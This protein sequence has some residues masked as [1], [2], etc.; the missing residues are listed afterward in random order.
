MRQVLILIATGLLFVIHSG[1]TRTS[2]NKQS[3]T[4]EEMELQ[5]KVDAFV[6]VPLTCNI[7]HLSASDR[8]VLSL[9]FDAAQLMDDLFW[10]EAYGDKES[11][12]AQLPN[13]TYRDFARINYGPWERLNG[14]E[15]FVATFGAKPLGANFYPQDITKEEFE[16]CTDPLKESMY[17]VL[18]RDKEGKLKVIPYHEFFAEKINQAAKLLDSA[19]NLAEDSGLKNYLTLRANA[20]RTDEYFASDMAWM[21]MKN[22]KIDLVVGPIENYEDHLYGTKAAHEAFVLVKDLEW[23]ERLSRYMSFLPELQKRLPIEDKYKSELPGTESDLGVYDVVFYAGDCNAGSKTIAINLPNDVKVQEQKGSRRLQLRN[24]MQYK[25]NMIMEPIANLLIDPAQRNYVTFEAFF[26]NT[27]FHE[28]AH[29]LGIK[30]TL[31]GKSTPQE[32]LL[33]TYSSIEE[34][35]ADILGIFMLEQLTKLGEL[36]DHDMMN[37]YVTF[38]AGIF[39]SVRFGAASAHGK[40]NMV[41]FHYFQDK[42]AFVRDSITG[43]YRIVPEK[44]SEAVMALAHEI[45]QIQGD[46]D[47]QRAAKML[48]QQGIVDDLLLEDMKKIMDANIP[49]D[50][51][52]EQG[53]E[54]LGLT[55]KH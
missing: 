50:I 44:M 15:P 34:G 30:R 18:R 8:N 6:Q 31:D 42:G 25:F 16:S 53:K 37:N 47:Y 40:A 11:F 55:P 3:Q 21:S 9:F 13:D 39:R 22:N 28:V 52:F 45:L 1:C 48:L 49:I 5:Q 46:G 36:P 2:E 20:L 33:E 27:M 24:A 19:A 23:S 4:E 7:E 17:S 41:R 51:R 32:A 26:E 14:N 43:F 35:K 54:I 29:G 12:L 38:L 10:Q